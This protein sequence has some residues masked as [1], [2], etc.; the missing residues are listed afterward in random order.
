M[1]FVPLTQTASLPTIGSAIER[2]ILDLKVK[3]A[4][5]AFEK[6]KDVAAFANHVGGTL[7]IGASEVDGRLSAYV[8]L[9]D[10]GDV[11]DAYSKA[12]AD[13]CQP[14]PLV[15]FEDF[16]APGSSTKRVV[17]VNVWPSLNLVG[18]KVLSHP[19][20]GGYGG[21][22]FVYPVRS[23]T[24][25]TYLEPGQLAMYMTP[26]VRRVAVMLSKIPLDTEV[27]IYIRS[28]S[29]KYTAHFVGVFEEENIAKFVGGD[30]NPLRAL[31]LDRILTV[32]ETWDS[33]LKRVVWKIIAEIHG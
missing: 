29:H 18:V 15:D 19:N 27:H 4:P 7:L 22:S 12:V 33:Q 20:P 16:A 17:A 6:A 9:D 13:L 24:D 1:R 14:H 25:A 26:S 3:P 10:A 31:P 28:E 5:N 32:Y 30:R 8:G 2:P 21:V 11:R 23:G